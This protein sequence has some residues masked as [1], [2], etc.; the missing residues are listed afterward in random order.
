MSD[1]YDEIIIEAKEVLSISRD[2]ISSTANISSLLNEHLNKN[3]GGVI[4][5]CGFYFTREPN[6]LL[7]GPFQGKVACVR[8]E[9]G[10]GVCGTAAIT[11]QSQIVYDVH[12]IENHIACDSASNSEIVVPIFFEGQVVGV[13]D[14]D[15]TRVGTFNEEDRVGLEKISELLSQHCDW[16]ILKSF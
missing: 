10:K 7:V 16:K 8:I 2:V 12:Q 13:I 1:L 9:Y 15:S 14:I 5:W 3:K 6:V 11:R 4:N